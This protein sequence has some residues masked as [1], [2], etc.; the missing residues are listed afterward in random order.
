ATE[1]V[2]G[3]AADNLHAAAQAPGRAEGAGVGLGQDHRFAGLHDAER[4]ERD[5]AGAAAAVGI[6]PSGH[7]DGRVADVGELDE[8]AVGALVHELGDAQAATEGRARA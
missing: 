2:D 5:V 8:L 3:V 6:A 1:V 7:V 4:V